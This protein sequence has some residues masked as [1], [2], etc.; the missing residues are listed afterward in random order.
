VVAQLADV[1]VDLAVNNGL[2]TLNTVN[3][4]NLQTDPA[5]CGACGTL[6]PN[7][8][9]CTAGVCTPPPCQP[10]EMSCNATATFQKEAQQDLSDASSV[11]V[12]GTPHLRHRA[13]GRERPRG[14]SRR[15]RAAVRGVRRQ[16]QGSARE[17]P[18]A[19]TRAAQSS[20]IDRGQSSLSS[21]DC[22]RS[23]MC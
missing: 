22:E 23:A 13:H 11:G 5:N 8:F 19:L 15:R 21:L 17:E 16:T 14:H 9:A 7:G 18:N 2:V 12:T 1:V 3:L 6:C 10:N 20:S 4:D